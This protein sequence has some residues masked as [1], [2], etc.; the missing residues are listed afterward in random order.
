ML[1]QVLTIVV[2]I[3]VGML[4]IMAGVTVTISGYVKLR[5]HCRRPYE[6]L[7]GQESSPASSEGMYRKNSELATCA[8]YGCCMFGNR[9]DACCCSYPHCHLKSTF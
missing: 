4:I 6:R 7:P 1:F 8:I 2:P 5:K 3:S 9:Y